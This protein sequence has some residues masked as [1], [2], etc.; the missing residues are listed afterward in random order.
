M[1]L[2]LPAAAD[3]PVLAREGL[4]YLDSAATAQTASIE[5]LQRS[6]QASEHERAPATRVAGREQR[7]PVLSAGGRPVGRHEV[8]VG[9]VRRGD[10]S[11]IRWNLIDE[12]P[13]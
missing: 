2:A 10:H 11:R 6:V 13:L 12:T 9:N 7:L 4:T 5:S 8:H 3:F 1:S